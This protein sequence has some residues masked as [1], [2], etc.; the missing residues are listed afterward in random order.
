MASRA[1]VMH[2]NASETE[3]G[4]TRN[5]LKYNKNGEIVSKAKHNAGKKSPWSIAI[6]RAYKELGLT[7]FVPVTKGSPLYELAKSYM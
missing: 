7:G 3:T 4:I 6:K 2:H 1:A 5:N